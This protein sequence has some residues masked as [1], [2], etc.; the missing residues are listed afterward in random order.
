[1]ST[2][3]PLSGRNLDFIAWQDV[4]DYIEAK[5]AVLAGALLICF[6][7]SSLAIAAR[8]PLWCDEIITVSIARAPTIKDLLASFRLIYDQTPPL[9]ALLVRLFAS[10]FGWTDLVVRLPSTISVTLGLLILFCGVRRVTSGVF[11]LAAISI[12]LVTFLPMYAYEARPYAL[13]FF[14]STLAF[15]LWTAQ[16]DTWFGKSEKLRALF[17]GLAMTLAVCAHYYGVLLITPFVAEQARSRGL[18]NLAAFRLFCGCIG[19]GLALALHLPLI[20]AAS[21][22]L[23]TP[24]SGIPSLHN[25]QRAYLEMQMQF[26]FVLVCVI[27]FSFWVG[28]R[29]GGYVEKQ[30]E[31]ERLGWFFLGIPIAGYIVAELATHAFWPR[32]FIPLLAGFG[33]AFGCFLYRYY[34]SSPEVPLL[35]LLVAVPLFLETALSHFRNARTPIISMRNEESDFVDQM[36]PRFKQEGKLCLLLPAGSRSYLEARYYAADPQMI[37]VL[38]APDLPVLPVEKDPLSIRYFSLDDLRQH[39]RETALVGPS[40]ELLSRVE[41]MGFHI[42]WRMTTPLAVAY[43]E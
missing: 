6:A 29:N 41:K 28:S 33:F 5:N 10:L 37:R 20:R 4:A 40:P 34:R 1:M 31:H 39:A 26:S 36:L 23:G 43:L 32:Y 2:Q 35:I 25:L 21:R 8:R 12:L 9:N 7:L 38:R 22:R 24:F 14:A 13:L 27:L 3:R 17:F 11:G 18:R 19:V 30:S 16:P 42:H 15:W